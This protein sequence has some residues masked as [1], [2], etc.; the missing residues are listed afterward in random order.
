MCGDGVL[1]FYIKRVRNG[2]GK[3]G[4]G[5]RTY[6]SLRFSTFTGENYNYLKQF[7]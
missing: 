6:A 3:G 4:G 7:K 5:V 1:V 2:K